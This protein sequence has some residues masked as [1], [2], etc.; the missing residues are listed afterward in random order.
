MA[1]IGM[2]IMHDAIHGSYSSNKTVNRFMGYTLNLIGA[3]TKVWKLQHNVLHHAYT[4]IH[5]A[6]DDINAPY[7]LRFTPDA[8][9]YPIHRFQYLYIWIFYGI[10]TIFWVTGKDFIR[11]RRYSK[12]GLV[13]SKAELSREV[14]KITGWKIFYF[15]YALVLPMI[16]APVSPWIIVLA[17][18]TMH[19]ITGILISLIFQVAHVM[20]DSN[21]PSPDESGKIQNEWLAHQLETTINFSPKSRTFSWFIGGLNYQVEHHLLPNICHVHYRKLSHIVK[22]TAEEYNLYYKTQNSFLSAVSNHVRMLRQLGRM[23][24]L[25]VPNR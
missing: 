5:G 22:K 18:L 24:T 11:L 10:S 16:M 2:G 6:D 21:F 14:V 19:F 20:P 8:K 1:G 25:P 3:S 13:K 17:F 4:N 12:M 9:R 15:G 23:D 7:F